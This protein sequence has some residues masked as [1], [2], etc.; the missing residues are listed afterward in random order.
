M[1]KWIK[2]PKAIALLAFL[3]PWMTV[4]CSGNKLV[5]ATGAGLAFGRFTSTLDR[6]A[7][8]ASQSPHDINWWLVLAIAA[9]VIGLVVALR[10]ASRRNA[11]VVMVTSVAGLLFVWLGTSRYGKSAILA[12]ISK[13]RDGERHG[14]EALS[15]QIDRT[16][17][18][19]IQID[20]HFGFW[21][22]LAAL[23]A[24]A[25]MAWLVWSGRDPAARGPA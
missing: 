11:L 3:L 24:A 5:S 22:A 21:L 4:S 17:D 9:I 14:L 8:L 1:W 2:I 23:V 19:M 25:A 6:D 10:P 18:A 15:G 13:R 12:E 16:A 20:W 7:Q